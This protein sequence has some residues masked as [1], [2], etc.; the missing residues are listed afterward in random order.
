MRLL[1]AHEA[2]TR[3]AALAEQHRASYAELSRILGRGDGYMSRYFGEGVPYELA[4][5]D[6][7]RLARYFGVDE[8][9]LRQLPQ[10]RPR[11]TWRRG[12]G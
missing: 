11:L 12:R 1:L 4:E 3:L 6:R 2:R 9:N 10:R 7:R 8:V 5:P